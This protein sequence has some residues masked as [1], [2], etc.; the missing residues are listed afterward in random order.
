MTGDVFMKWFLAA[1]ALSALSLTA[2]TYPPGQLKRLTVP[3]RTSLSP[4]SVSALEIERE[5]EYPAIIHLKG[6]VEIKTP[7]CVKGVPGNALFC[8]GYVVL[9]ADQADFHEDSGQ[10][11]AQGNVT[12]TREQ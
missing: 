6:S 2:Q 1:L 9:H 7:V 12:V 8:A 11:E 10:T 3:T 5:G 4:L